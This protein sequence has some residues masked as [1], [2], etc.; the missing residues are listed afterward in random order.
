MAACAVAFLDLA[1]EVF[2]GEPFQ[3]GFQGGA[4]GMGKDDGGVD[5]EGVGHL[6]GFEIGVERV[7]D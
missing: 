1:R 4:A 2:L 7:A 5:D 3:R 6:Q